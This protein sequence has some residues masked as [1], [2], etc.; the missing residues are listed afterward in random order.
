MYFYRE[1]SSKYWLPASFI[2][3]LLSLKIRVLLAFLNK[4]KSWNIFIMIFIICKIFWLIVKTR[5]RTADQF[6]S[7]FFYR[8]NF[9]FECLFPL[10]IRRRKQNIRKWSLRGKAKDVVKIDEFRTIVSNNEV[11]LNGRRDRLMSVRSQFHAPS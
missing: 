11:R 7:I 10:R 3:S 6:L 8:K 4:V 5:I 9:L 1:I 2:L